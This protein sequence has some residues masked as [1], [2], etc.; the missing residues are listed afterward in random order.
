MSG[1]KDAGGDLQALVGELGYARSFF[2]IR[3]VD[4]VGLR[5]FEAHTRAAGPD[6][7]LS[8]VDSEEYFGVIA[9]MQLV[10]QDFEILDQ[11]GDLPPSLVDIAGL[12]KLFET[13]RCADHLGRDLC[14]S[15][16]ALPT[17]LWPPIPHR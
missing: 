16:G 6:A 11:S 10:G 14:V 3:P 12:P 7:Q 2:A 1:S 9:E 13:K 4:Q 8:Y 17:L 15:K 5:Y